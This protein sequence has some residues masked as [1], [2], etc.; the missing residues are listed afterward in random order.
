MLA[1]SKL[2]VSEKYEC[3]FDEDGTDASES[4]HA[5]GIMLYD[6]N[7]STTNFATLCISTGAGVGMSLRAARHFAPSSQPWAHICFF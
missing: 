3:Y 4:M 5:S 2:K 6:F 1:I 7:V